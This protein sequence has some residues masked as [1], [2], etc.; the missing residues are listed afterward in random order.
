M[1][2]APFPT[3]PDRPDLYDWLYRE[4]DKDVEMYRR[5]T[6]EH[7]CIL[8]CAV[9]TGRLAVPLAENGVE[10]H[11]IDNSAAMLNEFR[12]KLKT[13]PDEV[14]QRIHLEQA[15]MRSF[16]LGRQFSFVFIPFG[17]FVYLLTLDDQKSCLNALRR[18]LAPG[19]TLV[20]D[21]PT[22]A[23]AKDERWLENDPTVM[24]VQQSV[25]PEDGRTTEMW[26]TFRFDATTQL[27]EQD[28]HFRIYDREG[29]LQTERVVVWRSRFFFPG[30][31]YLQAEACGLE[32][33]QVY[34]DFHFGPFRH[35]SEVAVMV[36]QAS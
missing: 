17:S 1:T 35:D 20:I 25:D 15:D 31:F 33:T 4:T 2:R 13:L 22:W 21:I 23:E 14:A 28:R 32:I 36:M 8:E 16:D 18:H 3:V 24:K 10:V 26:S 27:M 29:T 5:L 7:T 9:G 12:A 30:E 11:G 6:A 19:G 34:G